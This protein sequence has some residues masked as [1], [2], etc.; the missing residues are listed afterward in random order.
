[1]GCTFFEK[2]EILKWLWNRMTSHLFE[3]VNEL[4]A[5]VF[6]SRVLVFNIWSF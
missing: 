4:K 3:V 2:D 6:V 5:V 1:M